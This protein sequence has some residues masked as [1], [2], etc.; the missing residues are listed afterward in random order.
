MRQL[1][2]IRVIEVTMTA[3]LVSG[4]VD[5]SV[6]KPVLKTTGAKV[7]GKSSVS[8][9]DSCNCFKFCMPCW[10]KKNKRQERS[11]ADDRVDTAAHRDF[12]GDNIP[13]MMV[14]SDALMHSP[15]ISDRGS[16]HSQIQNITVTVHCDHSPSVS[17]QGSVPVDLVTHAGESGSGIHPRL[18]SYSEQSGSSESSQ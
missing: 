3:S 4:K 2:K 12:T 7:V 9:K 10:G 15:V 11:D 16:N 13:T 8:V 14:P 18:L 6:E 17:P 5:I 1:F